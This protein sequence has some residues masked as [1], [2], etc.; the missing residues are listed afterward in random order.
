[1]TPLERWL[2]TATRGLS[3]ESAE[4]VRAE[5]QQ[6]Y[7]LT[8]EAGEDAIAVL[9]D[10]RAANRAYRKVLLT[11][12]EA[13]MAA[14]LTR[15]PLAG[16]ALAIQIF[17]VSLVFLIAGGAFIR[18]ISGTADSRLLVSAMIVFWFDTLFRKVYPPTTLERNHIYGYLLGP[19]MALFAGL[20][21]WYHEWMPALTLG[22]GGF[23]SEYY[24]HRIRTS[25]FRKLAAGQNYSL[26]PGEPRLTHMEA[27]FL[28]ALDRDGPYDAIYG[29]VLVL[30]AVAMAAWQP[31]TFAPMAAFV[32]MAHVTRTAIPFRTVAGSRRFRIAKWSVMAGAAL[33]PVL[34]GARTP[35]T[36]AVLLVLLFVLFDL[37]SIAL[38]RKVPV[39]EW[40]RK[41]YW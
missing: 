27:V 26:L 16:A 8:S 34:R 13:T 40:P 38:R 10:P 3:A 17:R 4:R 23:A 37:R 30:M 33:L 32:V 1:M 11:E 29:A 35:W 41:L 18:L 5:I 25:V 6:H 20:G 12:R 15:P 36:G 7:D 14:T 2:S 31:A 24:F 19:R 21:W 22:A 9:G 39:S 28:R